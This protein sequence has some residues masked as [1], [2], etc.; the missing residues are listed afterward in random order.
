MAQ[1]PAGHYAVTDPT[2]NR[3][4]TYWSVDDHGAVRDFP[5]G[6]RYR[7][8]PPTGWTKAERADWYVPGGPYRLWREEVAR[9]ISADPAAAARRFRERFPEL[10]AARRVPTGYVQVRPGRRPVDVQAPIRRKAEALIVAA[11]RE[12]GESFRSIADILGITLNRTYRRAQEGKALAAASDQSVAAQL[13]GHLSWLAR[14][15]GPALGGGFAEAVAVLLGRDTSRSAPQP[16]I[17]PGKNSP[18]H[19][20]GGT[21]ITRREAR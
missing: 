6:A 16:S 12:N 11:L 21:A 5:H 9:R 3:T 13:A 10:L 17:G 18:I 1:F 19:R 14:F 7:P 20:G 8:L 2:D 15:T 4:M